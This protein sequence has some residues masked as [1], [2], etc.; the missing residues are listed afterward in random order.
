MAARQKLNRSY[1]LASLLL[2]GLVGWVTQSW[3][4]FLG[5][6]IILVGGNLYGQEIRLAKRRR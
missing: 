1:F 4:A 6:L 3:L 2:A 5:A